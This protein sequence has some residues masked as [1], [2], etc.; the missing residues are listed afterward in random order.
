M[1]LTNRSTLR[2]RLVAQTGAVTLLVLLA[3]LAPLGLVL[4][5]AAQHRAVNAATQRALALAPRLAGQPALAAQ[6]PGVTVFLPEGDLIGTRAP[7]TAA[8]ELAAL[9]GLVT[10]RSPDGVDVLVPA[11][12]PEGT[13]VV[14]VAVTSGQ[15]H[16]G[17]RATML[18]LALLGAALFALALIVA[19]RLARRVVSAT[20][21]LAGVA[22]RLTGGDLTAR[23]AV[24]GPLELQRIATATNR[25]AGRIQELLDDQRTEAAELAHSLRTPLTALRLEAGSA[26]SPRLIDAVHRMSSAVDEVIRASRRPAREGLLPSSDLAGV[27]RQRLAFWAPLAE[28]TGRVVEAVLPA[29]P[30]P[31]RLSAEDAATLVDVLLDNVFTHTPATTRTVVGVVSSSDG[32]TSGSDGSSSDGGAILWI[33]DDGP[34]MDPGPRTG[35]TGMGLAIATRIAAAAHATLT[36]GPTGPSGGT[37]VDVRFGDVAAS[38]AHPGASGHMVAGDVPASLA[39]PGASGRVVAG[40]EQESSALTVRNKEE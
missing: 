40:G 35:S 24:T 23:A 26:G 10:V 19:D 29:G 18:R 1:R 15:L 32:T 7:R 9:G 8:V 13:A 14:R 38:V 21:E 6:Q 28:E 20:R 4:D 2:R 22:D 39:H 16:D 36:C 31:V 3:F 34:G 5:R 27:V 30:V 11:P 12:R 37:R 33:E 25:L 17:V